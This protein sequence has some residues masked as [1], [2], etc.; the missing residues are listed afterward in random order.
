MIINISARKVSFEKLKLLGIMCCV[1]KTKTHLCHT[2]LQSVVSYSCF[3]TYNARHA[4][5][6]NQCATCCLLHTNI[7]ALFQ[8][9]SCHQ[10]GLYKEGSLDPTLLEHSRTKR[11]ARYLKQARQC[12]CCDV[13]YNV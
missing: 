5:Y 11:R 4:M 10:R 12:M 3:V 6:N 1:S 8:S 9:L 2:Q 13:T 7:I